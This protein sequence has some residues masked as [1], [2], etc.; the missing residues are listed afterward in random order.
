MAASDRITPPKFA[1]NE[2][3]EV[4]YNLGV[5]T[6]CSGTIIE[7]PI[8]K[9][10]TRTTKAR[11]LYKVE[12]GDG[13]ID[14]PIEEDEIRRMAASSLRLILWAKAAV[15]GATFAKNDVVEV[16]YK[17]EEWLR[18]VVKEVNCTTDNGDRFQY[19][20][21]FLD[22]DCPIAS[23]DIDFPLYAVLKNIR[24]PRV[25]G[26]GVSQPATSPFGHLP[27]S[28]TLR[29]RLHSAER[30]I[31]GHPQAGDEMTRLDNLYKVLWMEGCHWHAGSS[32]ERPNVLMKH[33]EDV[34]AQVK[35][36]RHEAKLVV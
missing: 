19:K 28:G 16:K 4:E 25:P 34:V 1:K 35:A 12:F 11:W 8:R 20:F 22:A 36:I 31:Y 9:E 23:A 33:I 30:I 26:S 7:D 10:A 6:W 14:F 2:A 18:A 27:R 24:W 21:E 29:T 5:N 17:E 32:W 15:I 3:V 13:D